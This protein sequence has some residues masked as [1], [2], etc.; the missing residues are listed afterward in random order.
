MWHDGPRA[1]H[2]RLTARDR[3]LREIGHARAAL[4]RFGALIESVEPDQLGAEGDRQFDVALDQLADV[5]DQGW[6]ALGDLCLWGGRSLADVWIH[7]REELVAGGYLVGKAGR[8]N[9]KSA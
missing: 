6:N 7:R 9:A 4:E 2:H 1:D 3:A 8:E 5:V